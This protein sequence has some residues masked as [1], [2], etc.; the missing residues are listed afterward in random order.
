MNRKLEDATL[1]A[2]S[3]EHHTE[4]V[5]VVAWGY[6]YNTGA[7]MVVVVAAAWSCEHQAGASNGG[8]VEL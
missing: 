1:V 4:A 3:C 8:R 2:W 6:E 5:M 7:V